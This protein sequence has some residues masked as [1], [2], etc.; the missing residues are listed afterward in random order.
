MLSGPGSTLYGSGNV[1]GVIN[2]V[3]RRSDLPD[4]WSGEARVGGASAT[5][6]GTTGA[7]LAYKRKRGDVLLSLDGAD[8]GDYRSAGSTEVAGSG[9]RDGTANL[10][11]G[12]MPSVAQRVTMQ[13]QAYEG[14][15]IGWPAMSGATIPRESRYTLSAD[16]GVQVGG[17]LVDAV[18]ARAYVQRLEHHMVIDMTMPMTMPNGMAGTM[19][20]VTDARSHSA[21]SGG[22][23][24]VR[25]VPGTNVRVDAGLDATQWAAE[26]TRWVETQRLTPTPGTPSATTLRTWPAVRVLDAGSFVQGEWMATDALTLSAGGRVDLID[27][28]A[29]GEANSSSWVGTGNLGMRAQLPRGFVARGTVGRGY[30]VADPTELY[31]LALRPDGYIYR[32]TPTLSP[33]TNLNVEGSLGWSRV[34]PAGGLDVS[35]TAFRNELHDL[36]APQLAA[37][38]TVSGRPVREY[39]NVSSARLSGVTAQVHV[40]LTDVL[41]LR[42]SV[43]GT[44]GED[45]STGDPLAAVPP[46]EGSV[47]LRLTVPVGRWV[48][49]EW[50]G[51]DTQDHFSMRAGE[52]RSPG[53]GILHL[54][55]GATIARLGVNAGVENVLDRAYRAHVDPMLLLRPGRNVYLRLT[56]AF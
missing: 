28:R 16:Y 12:L 29:D 9:Y 25:L 47:A 5:P 15:D 22:R 14:R 32:G 24:L 6:G 50:Q 30:R 42:G 23:A 46:L 17:R 21:T 41:A 39:V 8:F 37:G 52:M 2:V 10:T 54:R 44:R 48:E 51:A 26:A 11:V 55:A 13:A 36:I 49:A 7:T 31:G 53:Y 4:G 3:T 38:D 43:S 40:D 33:E 1:G 34:M 20:S 45:L 27:R 56:R 35:L 19:Q 18:T